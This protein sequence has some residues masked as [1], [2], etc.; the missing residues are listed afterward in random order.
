MSCCMHAGN[1]PYL[2]NIHFA[3]FR[4]LLTMLLCFKPFVRVILRCIYMMITAYSLMRIRALRNVAF[5]NAGV[6]LHSNCSPRVR[7]L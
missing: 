4:V 5:T 6:P 1:E 2:R 7:V 3:S